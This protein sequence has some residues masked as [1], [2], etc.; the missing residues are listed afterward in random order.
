M[1]T[2]YCFEREEMQAYNPF[3]KLNSHLKFM[4][5]SKLNYDFK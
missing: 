5:N 1:N 3:P 4:A 2:I